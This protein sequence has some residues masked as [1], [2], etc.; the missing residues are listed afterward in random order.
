MSDN[1][2]NDQAERFVIGH[3][4][5]IIKRRYEV[6]S[7]L[8]DFLIAIWFLGGSILFLYPSME[9]IAIWL[10]IIGSAQF[11]LRPTLRLASHIHLQRIPESSWER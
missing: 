5:L 6:L 10:F 8:N 7:I 1:L 2:E 11:L 9:K 3:E 4:E